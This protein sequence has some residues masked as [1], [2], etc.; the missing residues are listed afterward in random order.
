MDGTIKPS[1]ATIVLFEPHALRAITEVLDSQDVRSL[2]V[3]ADRVACEKSGAKEVLSEALEG[4]E[5]AFFF[6]FEPHP[7]WEDVER[8]LALF[9]DSAYDAILAVGGGTAVD[10]GKLIGLSS[11]Q[12]AH[13][14][15]II[16]TG[17]QLQPRSTTFI[18]AP[19]TAGTGSEATH[20][21]VL[22]VDGKKYS[23]VHE[24][25]LPD[26][27][28]IDPTLTYSLPPYQTAAT[29]LDALCQGIES[30]WSVNATQESKSFAE[31]AIRLAWT[32]LHDAVHSPTPEV[33]AAM[34]RAAH[35]A[36]RAINISKTTACHALSYAISMRYGL[37]HGIAVALTMGPVFAFNTGITDDTNNDPRSASYVRET[38]HELT[39]LLSCE[40]PDEVDARFRAFT[41][42]LDCP[43]TLSEAGIDDAE[44]LRYIAKSVNLE[45]LA[46]NPR[47]LSETDVQKILEQ[48][49]R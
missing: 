9:R 41:R 22:Y 35:Q 5:V 31:E 38:M 23:V 11:A 7:R 15:D 1:P 34:C 16:K 49:R 44:D 42:S 43:A 24:S 28:I 33:R 8:G 14:I 17:A 21:A 25:L 39:T 30:Y 4:R 3:V 12:R 10:I 18:A 40:S 45:R 20:F 19:T 48:S 29:G 2:F 13:P 6:D 26:V 47:R 32:C 27:A 46:N 37:P 36:G